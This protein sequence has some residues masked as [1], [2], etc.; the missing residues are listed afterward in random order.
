MATDWNGADLFG[1]A[2]N[3]RLTSYDYANDLHGG[4]GNDIIS[5]YFGGHMWG[6]SGNDDFYFYLSDWT[7]PVVVE[8]FVTGVDDLLIQVD[9]TNPQLH[10]PASGDIYTV[11]YNDWSGF[12]VSDTF[13][14]DGVTNI[15]TS[16]YAFV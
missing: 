5:A 16:D 15:S 14:L 1:G 4:S 11:T 9:G 7:G 8:D 13:E 6:D 12:Q 3:D 2:G 10:K